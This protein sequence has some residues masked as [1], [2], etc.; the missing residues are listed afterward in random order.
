MYVVAATFWSVVA[1]G[2]A[3]FRLDGLRIE[4]KIAYESIRIAYAN[5]IQ[6]II[7]AFEYRSELLSNGTKKFMPVPII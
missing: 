1:S 3:G 4:P 7:I 5:R 2:C 6:I